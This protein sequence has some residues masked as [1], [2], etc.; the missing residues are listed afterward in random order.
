M[1]LLLLIILF[2]FVVGIPSA[3]AIWMVFV[4]MRRKS[5]VNYQP[6]IVREDQTPQF[7]PPEIA[8]DFDESFKRCPKCKS[9][10]TDQTLSF[11][12]VDGAPLDLVVKQIQ[13]NNLP[14]TAIL[15]KPFASVPTVYAKKVDDDLPPT[16][17]S[18]Y[19]EDKNQN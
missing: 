2:L 4:K 1:E 18:S 6:K 15:D 19:L 10:F 11:C 12:L 16:V 9:T 3:V 5:S 13:A 8:E 14:V 17:Q 7:I